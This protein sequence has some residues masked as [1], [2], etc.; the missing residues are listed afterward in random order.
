M[1]FYTRIYGTLIEFTALLQSLFV[2]FRSVNVV[3]A[4]CIMVLIS[5]CMALI[6]KPWFVC[7]V[8]ACWFGYFFNV[9]ERLFSTFFK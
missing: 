8:S 9:S 4:A 1:L 5:R 6:T 2:V 7:N 3:Q